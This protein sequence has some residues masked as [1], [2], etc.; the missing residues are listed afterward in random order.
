MQCFGIWCS[1][2]RI[3]HHYTGDDNKLN[4]NAVVK[5]KL[6]LLGLCAMTLRKGSLVWYFLFIWATVESHSD[7]APSAVVVVSEGPV[8]LCTIPFWSS[9]RYGVFVCLFSISITTENECPVQSCGLVVSSF[10]AHD[11]NNRYKYTFS[12][13]DNVEKLST[14]CTCTSVL[15]ISVVLM[16][17]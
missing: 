7:R 10:K 11:Q 13:E 12:D 17:L 9:K 8:F 14:F 16:M 4:T 15:P 3:T 1:V 5:S 6:Q 2:Y